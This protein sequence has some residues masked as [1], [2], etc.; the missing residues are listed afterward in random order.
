MTPREPPSR[1]VSPPSWRAH[2]IGLA[3]LAGAAALALLA[4]WRPALAGWGPDHPVKAPPAQFVMPDA[5]A[6][7]EVAVLSG[8]CFWG[9]QGVFQHVK[10][11]KQVISGYSG[12]AAAAANYETV[13]SGLTG[14]AETVKI[15]FD[16]RQVRY[17][18][19]L[20]VYFSVATDPTQLNRQFPDDGPQYRGEIFYLD[21]AQQ[22]EASH[23]IAQLQDA[24]LYSGKIVTRLDPFH[25]FF[26]AE[27]YHQ[28]FLIKHP[29]SLYI[30]T[31]DMPKLAALKALF[32]ELYRATPAEG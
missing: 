28:N 30:A 27:A 5:P 3:G 1:P 26:P 8:G 2:A 12:G 21:A 16:P 25:G 4:L 18:D 11:V 24:H 10:G 15:V 9:M 23:Y 17:V 32:P 20:R 22:A 19:L 29:D 6:A 14:H 13:S 31:Y 7:Q